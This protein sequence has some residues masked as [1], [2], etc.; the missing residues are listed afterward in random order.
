MGKK[1]AADLVKNARK[2]DSPAG[3]IHFGLGDC[4]DKIILSNRINE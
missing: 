3:Y 4:T 2:K 1:A